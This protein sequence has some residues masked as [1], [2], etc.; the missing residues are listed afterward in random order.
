MDAV[1]EVH[2]AMPGY[3]WSR[4][5]HRRCVPSN[6]GRQRFNILGAYSP[7][8]AEYVDLETTE[9]IN[10][11]SVV[12]LAGKLETLHPTATRIVLIAD[13]VRYNHAR[14]LREQL[15]GSHVEIMYLPAYAP[16]LN[17]IERLWKF[18]KKQV[19][20]NH[21]YATFEQFV[22]TIQSFLANLS[23]YADELATLMVENF[24]IMTCG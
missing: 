19:K 3:G 12:Q 16:N 4:R 5:G 7:Q 18:M 23:E 15:G 21:F 13:N 14:L 1:H 10:A 2:N 22:T 9:N 17:L 11:E 6:S 20:R 8:D 24:E